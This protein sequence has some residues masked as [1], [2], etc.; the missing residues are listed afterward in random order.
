M[1]NGLLNKVSWR[2]VGALR[3]CE[4]FLSA[5]FGPV[6]LKLFSEAS[7]SDCVYLRA[8][9]DLELEGLLKRQHTR[10]KYFQGSLMNAVD[11][12]RA[13][14]SAKGGQLG[15]VL[16]IFSY[17]PPINNQRIQFFAQNQPQIYPW[18]FFAILVRMVTHGRTRRVQNTAGHSME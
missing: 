15:T 16:E 14:V 7:T 12:E 13:K 8:E 3:A 4:G 18:D 9:P 17:C 1:L 2:E 11:L 5:L 6:E 10:I